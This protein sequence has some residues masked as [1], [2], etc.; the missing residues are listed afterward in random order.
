LEV[1]HVHMHLVPM[2]S[3]GDINFTKAKLNPTKE[4]LAEV[5]DRIRKAF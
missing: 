1:P 2:N 4:E 3:V 5:A